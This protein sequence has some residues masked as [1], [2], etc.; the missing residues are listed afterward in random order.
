ML[1][2]TTNRKGSVTQHTA[3][4]KPVS[5]TA[6]QHNGFFGVCIFTGQKRR[7]VAHTS[8]NAESSRSHSVFNV[9]LVQAPLDP[10]GE[11]VLQVGHT[12]CSPY[13][14]TSGAGVAGSLGVSPY[15]SAGIAGPCGVSPYVWCR[16]CLVT[17]S[18]TLH[19]VQVL[20]NH[21]F[22]CTS[23]AGSCGVSP[24]IWCRCCLVTWNFT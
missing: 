18:F 17:W 14:L 24:C 11:E 12:G 9:R 3:P 20:L 5:G 22:D 6:Y 21:V 19:L 7:K 23:V 10:R 16:C 15:V 13:D 2:L 8:L 1:S 4:V